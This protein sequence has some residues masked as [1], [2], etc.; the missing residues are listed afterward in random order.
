MNNLWNSLHDLFDTDDGSLP[1]IYLLNLSD[2]GVASIWTHLLRSASGLA[3]GAT[4]W[5]R[6]NEEDVHVDAV[7]NAAELVVKG[8]AESFHVLLRGI[9]SGGIVLPD[10][11][12][13]V[14]PD[15]IYL[16][17]RMGPEWGPPELNGLFELLH[18]LRSFDANALVTLPP[19]Y[20]P[21]V[22]KRFARAFV[23]Y[24]ND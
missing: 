22:Q 11:G 6:S 17:Y 3:G 16:D 4:F 7:S 13:F 19:E 23:E 14:F 1:D 15:A 12:V 8:E 5:H 21:E 24:V 18:R 10:L 2:S 20:D 9:S